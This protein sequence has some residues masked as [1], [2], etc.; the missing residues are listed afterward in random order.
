MEKINNIKIDQLRINIPYSWAVKKWKKSNKSEDLP[1][2]VLMIDNLFYFK[3][4][5][6]KGEDGRAHNGYT[7]AYIYGPT[8]NG[9][10]ITIE[11]NRNRMDM[12]IS[13][14]F[15]ALGKILYEQLAPVHSI[16]VDWQRIIKEVY[17]DYHGHL[18]RIDICV[19][20]INYGFSINDIYSR[21]KSEK[22]FFLDSKD[23]KIGLNRMKVI[24]SGN[25]IQC[26]YVG[27]RKSD[28]MLRAYSKKDEQMRPNGMYRALAMKANDWIR[29]EAEVK[30]RSCRR[31]GQFIADFDKN[32]NMYPYLL[33]YILEHW[34]LVDHEEVEGDK[35]KRKV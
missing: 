32:K 26:I 28:Q 35:E 8:E 16:V 13:I 20:L 9:G 15:T 27:S 4:I 12:G 6:K 10:K 31:L 22:S 18:S 25:E 1:V 2:E 19:D 17:V 14:N 34:S 33:D 5:F 30:Y 21:L 24:G 11:W 7:S 29:L 3:K 23:R